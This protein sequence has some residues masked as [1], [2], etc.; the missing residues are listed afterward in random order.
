MINYNNLAQYLSCFYYSFPIL[1]LVENGSSQF[2]SLD[3]NTSVLVE[4]LG[5]IMEIQAVIWN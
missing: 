4:I 2:I 1:L 3:S 5:Y